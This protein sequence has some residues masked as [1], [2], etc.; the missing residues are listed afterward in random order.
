MKKNFTQK[1]SFL[2]LG[3]LAFSSVLNTQAQK[4]DYTDKLVNPSFE[5]YVKD[6]VADLSDPI[7]S[8]KTNAEEPRLY[9]GAL[10][11]TPPG[12]SDSKN[13]GQVAPPATKISYGINR[14]AVNKD[15]YN[16]LFAAIAP[17][18]SE[19]T[20]YQQVTGLPAGQYIVSC[21]MWVG[22][23]KL[24][25]QRIFAS[26]STSNT[27]AQYYGVE[28]DYRVASPASTSIVDGETYSFAGWAMTSASADGDCRLKPMSV[29][30][31]VAAG[32][33]LTLGVKSSNLKPSGVAGTDNSGFYKV[34]DFHITK[35][36]DA[37]PNDYTSHIV[38]PSFDEV[39]VNNVPTLLKTYNIGTYD[40]A[41]PQ[42]GVP[43]GWHDIIDDSENPTPNTA[44]G[45][46]YGV[47]TDANGIHGSKQ[48]WAMRT[49][50]PSS[51]TLYQ[52]VTGLPAGRYKVSCT[53]YVQ[54]SFLTTQRL[55]ANNNVQY[56]ATEYDYLLNLNSN[57]NNTYAGNATSGT[58]YAD[59]LFLRNMSVEV[60]VAENE[61]LRLGIKSSNK[62]AD[63]SLATGT[64]GWFK[65]D[66]FRLQVLSLAN[67]T[68]KVE[69]SNVKVITQKGGCWISTAD[70]SQLQ[71]KIV[72]ATGQT[73][74][75]GEINSNKS[76]IPL[77]QGLY[78]VNVSGKGSLKVLVK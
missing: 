63:G 78:V 6:G 28:S 23:T 56:F 62:K 1:F 14:G 25:N 65:A 55:F 64:E 5:Y 39:L 37:D 46:S 43:Y 18:P 50:F 22:S 13:Y 59:G 71:V 45:Q 33:T 10:R 77:Q 16:A 8:T 29:V 66:N 57:E 2:A 34:D 70:E 35:V 12:W 15:G 41:D 30:I 74:Y 67:S 24:T 53:M 47:N 21:R 11:G 61:N 32:E 7:I 19:L 40:A 20:V 42:R 27:I 4:V 69:L 36:A 49:P 48:M 9:D 60:N 68:K 54:S 73:V 17:F 38:N 26:T 75:N 3:I 72:S 58:G 31:N 52:D 44:M 76:W 51:Y